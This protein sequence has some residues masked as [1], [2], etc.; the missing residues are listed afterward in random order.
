MITKKDK[1]IIWGRELDLKIV[2]DVYAGEEILDNQLQAFE[3]F[4]D[5]ATTL[6]SDDSEIKKYCKKEAGSLIDGEIENI[7]KY[8]MPSSVF[9]KRETDKHVVA[10]LCDFRFDE[11]HGI[12]ILFENE[13]L[14]EIGT[15]DII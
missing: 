6:F 4:K 2:Y 11:E 10:L 14:V 9:V 15:Q 1:F 13:K 3:S 5:K 12:A 8:V 7:F